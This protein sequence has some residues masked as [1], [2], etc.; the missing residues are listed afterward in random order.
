M[1]TAILAG[2]QYLWQARQD[3]KVAEPS[4]LKAELEARAH[5]LMKTRHQNDGHVLNTMLG[6]F[7]HWPP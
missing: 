3:G 1:V 2:F 4:R 5:I 7:P 6:N